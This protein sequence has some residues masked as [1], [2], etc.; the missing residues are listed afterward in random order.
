MK[1]EDLAD[2]PLPR[3]V[4]RVRVKSNVQLVPHVMELQLDRSLRR[5]PVPLGVPV[6]L[7]EMLRILI[8]NGALYLGRKD[9]GGIEEEERYLPCRRVIVRW[10]IMS[11]RGEGAG[12]L[13]W[14]WEGTSV[15]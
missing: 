5:L 2:S 8:A 3:R 12:S 14:L 6:C 4:P 7:A 11:L 1:K 9:R 13:A 15:L 10:R